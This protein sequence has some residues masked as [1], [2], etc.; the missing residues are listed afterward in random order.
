MPATIAS[1]SYT[2]I[3]TH[4]HTDFDAL[5][6]MLAAAKLWPLA[7]PVLPRQMNRNLEAFLA[8]YRDALPFVRLEDLPRRRIDHAI[9]VDTQAVQPV[10]GMYPGTTGHVVD[11]H[12]LM[13]ELSPGW[14]FSGEEVGATTTLLVER[15]AETA[16]PL[17]PVEATL[18]ALGI[19]EDTGALSYE[20]TTPRDLRS[21]G[22]LMERGANL[23]LVNK[24]LHHPLT[25]EQRQLYSQ[26]AENSQPYQFHGHSII[27]ATATAPQP[28]EE[29]STLAHKLHDLYEPDAIF[30]LVAM[31]GD[32][33]QFVARSTSD[34]V[35][36]G[37]IAAALGG[38]GH[39]RAAAALIREGTLHSIYETLVYLLQSHV[40]PTVTVGQIMSYGAPQTLAPGDTVADAAARV[41]RYGFEGFPVME[42]G[43]V[44][45]M[46][47]RREIDR[48]MHHGLGRHPISRYM[49]AGEVYVT[50]DDS[51]EQLRRVMTEQDWGQ[52]PVLDPQTGALLGI[53]TRTDLIKQWAGGVAP[54]AENLSGRMA[55]SLPAPL[56]DLLKEAGAAAGAMGYPLYAVGGFVRDLL[57][58][59]P[60]FDVDLVV[61]GDAIKLAQ[62]LAG[63][64]GGH[65]RSH[66]RFG[67]A[68]WLMADS[69]WPVAKQ[70]SAIGHTLAL[71]F[72]TARTE[73]YEHPTALPTVERS[74][75]KQDLHRRDFTINTL[76]V[77]LTPDRWG[78]LLDFYGGRR[79]LDDGLIRVL[80]NLSFVEDPTRILRAARF[81]QRFSFRIEPRTEE[82]IG[83][84]RD[85]LE[86]VSAERIRHELELIMAE[87]E[88]EHALGR[89]A[90]LGVLV[91]LHPELRCDPWLASKAVELR[92]QIVQ[93][94]DGASVAPP[95][96]ALAA[97]APPR[98]HMALF[99]Y[100]LTAAALG[101]FI[102]KFRIRREYRELQE[103]ASRGRDVV[104][105]LEQ[106]HLRPSEVVILLEEF[107]PEARLL[108]RVVSDSWLARQRLDQY[109]RRLRHVRPIL[110]G[111]DLRRMGIEPGR[112]YSQL[113]ERLRAAH[114]DG[115]ISTREEEEALVRQ[116][117]EG[118]T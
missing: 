11:H 107:T 89:L 46:L 87:A 4:E 79:D 90:D 78:E 114:L 50:P 32:H 37:K 45:G 59:T 80:H 74:S 49:R 44:I 35:D 101:E 41:S 17:A 19:Y 38:G 102:A 108:L 29:I 9:L 18:L 51:A 113:L 85:L 95:P 39:S 52:V 88:P 30:M 70:L 33:V 8:V 115:E 93:A 109:Q 21:A 31:G 61:E 25:D 1:P 99:T 112:I 57:L 91:A 2:V 100:N 62:A 117:W 54:Q 22:W 97:D 15:L 27:I 40:K 71:D 69:E 23:L 64:L 16:L 12:P 56:L 13:R 14:T 43:R 81:E 28:V 7:V 67:T 94:Q 34:A 75:I 116:V 72:V 73:F 68:K 36:V 118:K 55:K 48:A 104:R 42:S 5:A 82:L 10:R 106:N 47:T 53:V 92:S 3:L 110:D 6:A 63:R 58:E 76:A 98:L 96:M 77:R 20:T 24:F 86:R 111:D 105:R 84:A 103:E 60:N 26:L 66:R 83:D 65:V